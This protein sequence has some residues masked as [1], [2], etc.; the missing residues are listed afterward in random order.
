MIILFFIIFLTFVL[1]AV[2]ETWENQIKRVK[3]LIVDLNEI[4]IFPE[5]KTIKSRKNVEV[6]LDNLD[7]PGFVFLVRGSLVMI[8]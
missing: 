8:D 3:R 4:V 7:F 5:F 2:L 6:V 1:D